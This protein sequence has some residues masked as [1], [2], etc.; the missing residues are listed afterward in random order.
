MA[1]LNPYLTFN[2]TTEEAFNHYKNIFGGEFAMTMRF[3]DAKEHVPTPDKDSNRIMHIA[4]PIGKSVLMGSDTL[5]GQDVQQGTNVT[6]SFN[7]DSR[8]D[9]DRIFKGL[10]DGGREVM[11]MEDTFWGDYFGMAI[12]KFGINWM[13]NYS[14]MRRD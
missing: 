7:P 11:P 1:G 5:G 13:I 4:L 8:S 10:A 3:S 12:D 2:G 14:E 9:A 6:I